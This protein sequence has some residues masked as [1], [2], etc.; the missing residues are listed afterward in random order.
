M[1]LLLL[2]L[3]LVVVPRGVRHHL[4]KLRRGRSDGP[5]SIPS[6]LVVAGRSQSTG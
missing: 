5:Q 1:R 4:T 6:V 3:L 2:L